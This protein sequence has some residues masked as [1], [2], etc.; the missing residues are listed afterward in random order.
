M[1][2][3]LVIIHPRANFVFICGSM[4]LE[5][6]LSAHKYSGGTGIAQEL[7]TFLYKRGGNGVKKGGAGPKQFF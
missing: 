5:S 2:E 6:I 1:G 4:K 7:Q 3:V